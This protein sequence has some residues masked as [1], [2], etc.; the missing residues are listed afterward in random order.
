MTETPIGKESSLP[1]PTIFQGR[2]VK[3]RGGVI[4]IS[5]GARFVQ[6]NQFANG[7]NISFVKNPVEFLQPCW[8]LVGKKWLI[9]PTQNVPNNFL[10][11]HKSPCIYK[12]MHLPIN[13]LRTQKSAPKK[14]FLPAKS[15]SKVRGK[16][17][18]TRTNAV[19]TLWA[20]FQMRRKVTKKPRFRNIQWKVWDVI[21]TICV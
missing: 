10:Q 18:A 21:M 1:F 5:S 2:A 7:L 4:I 3:L 12:K 16:R 20:I 13:L 9:F 17:G 11:I 19:R 6:K 8:C 14:V 15:L